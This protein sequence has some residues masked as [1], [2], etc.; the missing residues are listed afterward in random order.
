MPVI[1]RIAAELDVA[2]SIDSSKL[3]V[4]TA[5]IA[6]GACIVNDV[7][8]LRAPGARDW[9]ASAGVGVCLMH[10]RGEPRHHAGESRVS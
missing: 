2:I 7:R 1:E 9:A 3:E 5:A 6:A 10:M 4:M 8:A